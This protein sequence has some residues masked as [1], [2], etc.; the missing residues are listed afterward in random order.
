PLVHVPYAGYTAD[1]FLYIR[2]LDFDAGASDEVKLALDTLLTKPNH[3]AAG[4]I[5]DLR[6]NPGGL[7]SEAYRTASLFLPMGTFIVGTD[8]R[9]R[10]N[11]ET[12][13]AM[14]G[15]L[16]DGLPM[17]VMVDGGSASAAEIVSGALQASDRAFLVGDTTFG[18]G[19]VQGF[20][21]FPDGDGLRLTIS[22]YYVGD[23]EY[24]NTFDSTLN[25][26]GNGLI[27]DY[28]YQYPEL[29]PYIGS[30][31]NSLL[32]QEFANGHSQSLLAVDNDSLAELAVIEAFSVFLDSSRFNFQSPIL[33]A[34]ETVALRAGNH[35]AGPATQAL[36]D[37]F[38]RLARE[39]DRQLLRENRNYVLMRLRQIAYERDYG[40]DR[41]YRDVIVP[42][43]GDIQLAASLL[44]QRQ[45]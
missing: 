15:D 7:F 5:L 26:V 28:F 27:P 2:L 16:T 29:D 24:L 31:E 33:E 30:L 19:L 35:H 36:A 1:D 42:N 21:S 38:V 17:A 37:R 34:A 45:Q 9:S 20:V 32:L 25:P 22:R 6:G 8:A 44:R 40:S 43:R 39:A 18:K 3:H 4:V 41:T 14:H 12:H 13:I 23:H 11:D 10:W